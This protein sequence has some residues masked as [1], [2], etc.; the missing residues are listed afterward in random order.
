MDDSTH[1]TEFKPFGIPAP[2]GATSDKASGVA[3]NGG[4]AATAA[5][6]GLRAG[7]AFRRRGGSGGDSASAA[8]SSYVVTFRPTRDDP[9]P[10]AVRLRILLKIALRGFGLRCMGCVEAPQAEGGPV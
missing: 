9:R 2:V 3:K 7:A 6:S 10:A 1:I 4:G 5:R 8:T